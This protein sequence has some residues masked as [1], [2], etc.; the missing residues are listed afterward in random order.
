MNKE[1][2]SLIAT[3]NYFMN[4]V[5]LRNK[6]HKVYLFCFFVSFSILFFP[7]FIGNLYFNYVNFFSKKDS[8]FEASCWQNKTHGIACISDT[9][10]RTFKSFRIHNMLKQNEVD[11]IVHGSS[12]VMGIKGYMF[13]K[14]QKAYNFSQNDNPTHHLI[15]ELEYFVAQDNLFYFVVALDW[16]LGFPM[17]LEEI[18]NFQKT[19][20]NEEEV[21]WIDL[22]RDA[23]TTSKV[24]YFFNK[25][26]MILSA[27]NKLDT[28]QKVFLLTQQEYVCSNGKVARDFNTARPQRCAGFC[29]DGS[30]DFLVHAPLTE[31]KGQESIQQ[32]VI[33]ESQYIRT[34]SKSNGISKIYLERLGKIIAKIKNK[35]GEVFFFI[36]PL[37]PGFEKE[38]LKTSQKEKLL[39]IKKTLNDF[40]VDNKIQILDAGQSEAYGCTV[41]EFLDPHH[42]FPSCIKKIFERFFTHRTNAR[43][44]LISP[45]LGNLP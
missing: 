8:E 37:L 3:S 36:P 42:A 44:G 35:N 18:P 38:I 6:K 11:T 24:K 7:V 32:A 20:P 21:S 28:F 15:S 22:I 30:T 31:E 45:D 40:A 16:A 12:T 26:W 34:L 23:L 5:L 9:T 41:S 2:I 43:Y 17:D 25:I 13:P 14:N 10:N 19:L 4:D 33:V 39:N 29:Y 27:N 1:D